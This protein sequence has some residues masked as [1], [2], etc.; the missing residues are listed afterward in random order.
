MGSNMFSGSNPKHTIY[1]I[2][3]TVKL[4]AEFVIVLSE[5]DENK[6][7]EAGFGPFEKAVHRLGAGFKPMTSLKGQLIRKY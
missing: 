1:A 7:K 5:K 2:S 3:F 4:C 6:Q